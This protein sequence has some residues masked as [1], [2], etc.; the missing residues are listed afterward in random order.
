MIGYSFLRS[1]IVRTTHTCYALYTLRV[2]E[3]PPAPDVLSSLFPAP[4]LSAQW[5]RAHGGDR[6]G[7]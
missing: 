5:G 3:T 6:A 4:S 1:Q 7:A 2:C